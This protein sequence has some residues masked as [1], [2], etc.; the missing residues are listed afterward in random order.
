MPLRP[1]YEIVLKALELGRRVRINPDMEI[2]F[3]EVHPYKKELCHILSRRTYK[4]GELV[5]T[6]EDVFAL[7]M[8][9]GAFIEL[10]EGLTDEDAFTIAGEN[11][12]VKMA[13]EKIEKREKYA[14]QRA[15]NKG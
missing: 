14:E 15:R 10:C 11:A 13:Q 1:K 3:G 9:I 8:S 6:R 4:G 12:L 7:D 2:T 5:S